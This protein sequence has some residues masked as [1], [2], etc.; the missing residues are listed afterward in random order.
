MLNLNLISKEDKDAFRFMMYRRAVLYMGG[1]AGVAVVVFIILLIPSFL[2][3][4]AQRREILRELT[5]EEEALRAFRVGEI[6]QRVALINEKIERIHSD[7]ARERRASEFMAGIALSG[8]IRI[9]EIKFDFAARTV[10]IRGIASTRVAL[11]AFRRV[12]EESGLV[13]EISIPLID[14]VKLSDAAFTL[15]GTLR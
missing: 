1:V 14:L 8:G 4:N 12:L 10:D 3:L 6:E 2:F 15:K 5:A 13:G 7:D 9:G 11:L